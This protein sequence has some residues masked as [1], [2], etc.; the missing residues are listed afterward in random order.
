MVK[1]LK[2][3]PTE[4]NVN[5]YINQLDND[6]QRADC[7]T[8]LK[9]MEKIIKSKA[10]LWGDSLIGFGEYHYHYKS[11]QE[12][13]WPLTG[14]AARKTNLTVY[15]MQGF[16]PYSKLLKSLGKTKHT[17][18]CLHIKKL[19]DVDLALLE[20]LIKKSVDYMHAT[21]VTKL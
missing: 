5:N 10:V 9:L 16:E 4:A 1:A 14:F 2:T 6:Q 13:D 21:Y 19:A 7:K 15:I 11:G 8:L 12:G 3:Q 20:E 18:S 17:K